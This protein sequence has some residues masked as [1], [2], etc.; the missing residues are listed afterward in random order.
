MKPFPL[1]RRTALRGK[2]GRLPASP[3]DVSESTS[4]RMARVRQVG[5]EPECIVAEALRQLGLRF[6]NH[7]AALPGRPDFVISSCGTVLQVHGC[8]WH[9]HRCKR[10]ALPRRH[11][12]YWKTKIGRNQVRDRSASRLLRALGWNVFTLWE[13]QL[14]QWPPERLLKH[15]QEFVGLKPVRPAASSSSKGRGLKQR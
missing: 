9:G 10:G 3:S 7:V 13:C 11:R 15:I 5:T 4:R 8:F 2:V 12:L 14:R 1:R 6:R